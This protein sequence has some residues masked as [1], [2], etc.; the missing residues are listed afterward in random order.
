M[1]ALQRSVGDYIDP[2][3]FHAVGLNWD[4]T[5]GDGS[6]PDLDNV[7][8]DL[9]GRIDDLMQILIGSGTD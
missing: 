1:I 2:L 3:P 9:V 6:A 5:G 8:R 7:Y 4:V